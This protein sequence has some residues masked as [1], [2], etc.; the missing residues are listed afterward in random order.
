MRLLSVTSRDKERRTI[1]LPFLRHLIPILLQSTSFP[2]HRFAS[3][4]MSTHRHVHGTPYHLFTSI[5]QRFKSL[6]N[7]R[8]I[9][10]VLNRYDTDLRVVHYDICRANQLIST[11]SYGNHPDSTGREAFAKRE[12]PGS[13]NSNSS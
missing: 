13:Q 10:K 9:D 12:G 5:P 11:L 3:R 7:S 2:V 8:L 6:L 1:M 4:N